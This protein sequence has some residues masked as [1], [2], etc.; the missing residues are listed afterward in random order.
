MGIGFGSSF[1]E[2]D[3]LNDDDGSMF[4]ASERREERESKLRRAKEIASGLTLGTFE[5]DDDVWDLVKKIKD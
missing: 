4:G 2:D 3:Y 1:D 5:R